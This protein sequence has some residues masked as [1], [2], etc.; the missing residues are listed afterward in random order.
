MIAVYGL[1]VLYKSTHDLLHDWGTTKKF[2]SIKFVIGLS[3]IQSKLVSW[4]I[5]RFRH[6]DRTW[7]IDHWIA[8][9]LAVESVIMVLLTSSAF[10]AEEVQPAKAQ[11]LALVETSLEHVRDLE[12]TYA[13][14]ASSDSE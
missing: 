10:P 6:P 7:L 12:T 2:I 3:L 11:Q 5:H 4:L 8:M 13:D 9:L 14:L 1:F